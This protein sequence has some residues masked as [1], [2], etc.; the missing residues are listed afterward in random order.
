MNALLEYITFERNNINNFAKETLSDY[1]DADLFDKLL[2][3][4]LND[5]YYNYNGYKAENLNE[6]IFKD[7]KGEL[8]KLV[9]GVD[10][11]V[12]KKL[13]EMYVFFYYVMMFDGVIEVSD[14]K[15]VNML[16]KYRDELFNETDLIYKDNISKYIE[17]VKD[18]R[19]DFVNFFKGD[20]FTLKKRNTS[21][22]HVFDIELKH[23]I[24]FPKIYSEFAID[25]VF[26]TGNIN[27]EKLV[28]LYYMISSIIIKDIKK[29]VYDNYYLLEFAPS[30][31][32]N[33]EKFS[34]LLGIIDN[35]LFRNTT[36]F[37]VSFKDYSRYSGSIKDMIKIG[38][39]F[40]LECDDE[41]LQDDSFVL[42]SMFDYIIVDETSG[43]IKEENKNIIYI[44]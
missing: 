37:K 35:D 10:Q 32:E 6:S 8:S 21:S 18:K 25:R 42:S 27:E 4:Y 12:K 41:D 13:K 26:N 7:L 19:K 29:C 1:Y 15:L 14:K 38:Y 24:D 20:E 43:Y 33:K 34:S 44:K 11:D 40:V 2:D 23:K 28:V 16:S 22:D 39:K 3:V 31:F 30:I 17:K 9:V 36:Y 5:R